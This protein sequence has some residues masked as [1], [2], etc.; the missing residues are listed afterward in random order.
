LFPFIK[1][2]QIIQINDK[3]LLNIDCLV[4]DGYHNL[5]KGDF[6]KILYTRPHNEKYVDKNINR[7]YNL[8]EVY[9]LIQLLKRRKGKK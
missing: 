5:A 8:D 1:Y 3:S 6:D 2:E 4:D 7:V 9:K